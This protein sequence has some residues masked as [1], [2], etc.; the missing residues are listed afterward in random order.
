MWFA[1]HQLWIE[2]PF[3]VNGNLEE[4]LWSEKL[5]HLQKENNW[6]F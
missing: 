3:E 1:L 2:C 6:K 5:C 4:T